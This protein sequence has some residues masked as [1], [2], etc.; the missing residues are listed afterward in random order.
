MV[1]VWR[2]CQGTFQKPTGIDGWLCLLHHTTILPR[3]LTIFR[4]HSMVLL[5]RA[6]QGNFHQPTGIA[7]CLRLLD[8]TLFFGR[9]LNIPM[10]S[11]NSM[12]LWRA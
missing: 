1:L 11:H 3:F 10:L 4:Q 9:F 12:V 5:W 8:H 7:V 6:C 2:A